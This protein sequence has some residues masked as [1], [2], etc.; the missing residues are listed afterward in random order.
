[1]RFFTD[2]LKSLVLVDVASEY[3]LDTAGFYSPRVLVRDPVFHYCEQLERLALDHTFEYLAPV[4][5]VL[6]S[7]LV[8]RSGIEHVES[9][10]MRH[11]LTL[12]HIAFRMDAED[13]D[14]IVSRLRYAN[15][16][17]PNVGSLTFDLSN[18][19]RM[20]ERRGRKLGLYVG[21]FP[22][23]RYLCFT[24]TGDPSTIFSS[25]SFYE[26]SFVPVIVLRPV[27]VDAVFND[28]AENL[29][30]ILSRGYHMY[31]INR[32][33]FSLREFDF[34]SDGFIHTREME[35]KRFELVV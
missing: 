24:S 34:P 12:R 23:V 33:P 5:D 8:G 17:L 16:V 19:R 7:L 31:V 20:Y 14:M 11:R 4:S 1:M 27:N 26:Y 30:N 22:S 6:T 2:N 35:K 29:L 9:I 21:T 10:L 32:K 25:R 28:A 18:Y 13:A 3:I 15:I